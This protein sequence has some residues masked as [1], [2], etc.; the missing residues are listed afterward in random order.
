MRRAVPVQLALGGIG[1]V[2]AVAACVYIKRRRLGGKMAK[3]STTKSK[4]ALLDIEALHMSALATG[5]ET[6]TDPETKYTVFTALAHNRRGYCCGSNCR[7]CPYGHANVGKPENI[8]RDRLEA[9][10]KKANPTV[11]PQKASVYTRTGDKGTSGLFSGERRPK[12]DLVFEALGA[13]DE[14]NS[15]VGI[16]LEYCMENGL[17]EHLE[18]VQGKLMDVGSYIATP[19]DTSAPDKVN[20]TKFTESEVEEVEKLIDDLNS[21]MPKCRAFVLPTGGLAASHLH[22]ARTI[23]RRC[24]RVMVRLNKEQ[25]QGEVVMK[26]INRLSDLLFVMAR[27]AAHKDGREDVWRPDRGL[28]KPTS[29][30]Q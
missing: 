15:M 3:S 29:L 13:V 9:K 30:R 24:E 22:M 23:C 2:A 4:Q 16:S 1:G 20:Y 14:C 12:D 10:E 18:K 8:R 17:K 19:R 28:P 21:R 6:Y 7:H 11:K 25:P 5:E 26:Y 27:Y